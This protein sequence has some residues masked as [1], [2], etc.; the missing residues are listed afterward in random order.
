MFNPELHPWSLM[1]YWGR[2]CKEP[3]GSLIR[4][5]FTSVNETLWSAEVA[6]RLSEKNWLRSFFHPVIPV[7]Q[8]AGNVTYRDGLYN[9]GCLT[10]LKCPGLKN[11]TMMILPVF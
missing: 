9:H 10:L 11:A 1:G 3:I 4:G 8:V 7:I 2:T 5:E 6:Y